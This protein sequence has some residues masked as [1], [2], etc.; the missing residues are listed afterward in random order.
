[1]E[2]HNPPPTFYDMTLADIYRLFQQID[3]QVW[4][5]E[6]LNVTVSPFAIFVNGQNVPL[7]YRNNVNYFTLD[8]P[9]FERSSQVNHNLL[10][11]ALRVRDTV[12]PQYLE[13]PFSKLAIRQGAEGISCYNVDLYHAST[14]SVITDVPRHEAAEIIGCRTFYLW[15]MDEARLCCN[16]YWLRETGSNRP[17]LPKEKD[18]HPDGNNVLNV[19]VFLVVPLVNMDSPR[20]L[21]H[22]VTGINGVCEII[23]RYGLPYGAPAIDYRSEMCHQLITTGTVNEIPGYKIRRISNIDGLDIRTAN[24]GQY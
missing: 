5:S 21:I 8:L 10:L 22:A 23:D 12:E 19:G 15:M 4:H 14:D 13:M 16:G 1:M 11:T 9:R 20:P 7:V 24:L 3:E 6:E 2:K 17:F 18:L